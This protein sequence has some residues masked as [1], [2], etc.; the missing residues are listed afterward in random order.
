[1]TQDLQ[2]FS[3]TLPEQTTGGALA[4][5][6]LIMPKQQVLV[7]EHLLWTAPSQPR[8]H[9]TVLFPTPRLPEEANMLVISG[10]LA[11]LCVERT[12]CSNNLSVLNEPFLWEIAECSLFVV[13]HKPY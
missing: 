4:S 10:C 12:F 9:A 3:P 13:G 1:M 8:H 11:A 5:L 2:C 7:K 6:K